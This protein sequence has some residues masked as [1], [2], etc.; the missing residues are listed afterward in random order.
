MY[1]CMY[2]CTLTDSNEYQWCF[3]S[4]HGGMM[5]RMDCQLLMI[6]FN[7][8]YYGNFIASKVASVDKMLYYVSMMRL[9]D[10][11]A[12]WEEVR[13]GYTY[14]IHTYIQISSYVMFL[15]CCSSGD[16]WQRIVLSR[17]ISVFSL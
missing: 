11:V 14:Y 2:V 13:T 1:V 7:T 6:T 15:L 5:D 10:K 8:F 17:S 12:L 4:G 9:D 3:E 16:S